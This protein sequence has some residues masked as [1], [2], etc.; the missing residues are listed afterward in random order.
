MIKTVILALAAALMLAAGCAPSSAAELKVLCAGSLQRSMTDLKSSFEH[1]TGDNITIS[2]DSVGAVMRRVELGE[3]ADVV[4]ASRAQIA[5]MVRQGKV[6]G[7]SELTIARAG[8]GAFVR[9]GT[10]T[11]DISSPD[12]FT[13]AL[14]DARSLAFN[15]PDHGGA[16]GAYMQRLIE[17]LGLTQT[18]R[19]K[20]VLASGGAAG[21][22]DVLAS[23][24]AELAFYQLV[25]MDAALEPGLPLP[26]LFQGYTLFG[27]GVAAASSEPRASR[28]LISFI[29][30]EEAGAV[31]RSA[32]LRPLY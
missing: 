9:K 15:N 17:R 4:I 27:A 16:A 25:Q 7:D 1:F 24:K 11:P 5:E 8:I 10:P 22:V 20:L 19:P 23:G 12:A 3:A 26:D 18:L 29:S 32:G 28:S 21:I 31:F 6:A 2:Y 30:S 13:K 14:L